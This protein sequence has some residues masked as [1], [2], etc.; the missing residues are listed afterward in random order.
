MPVANLPALDDD[1]DDGMEALASA[2]SPLHGMGLDPLAVRANP[3]L[4]NGDPAA[5]KAPTA[6]T[7]ASA[8]ATTPALPEGLL[9][10][11]FSSEPAAKPSVAAPAP[12]MAAAAAPS[13]AGELQEPQRNDPAYQRYLEQFAID[14]GAVPG[15]YVYDQR[16]D[17]KTE[18]DLTHA[19]P[20]FERQ[21]MDV[22]GV[23]EV[24]RAP[25]PAEQGAVAV[26]PRGTNAIDVLEPEA[27]GAATQ[28]HELEHKYQQSR[29]QQ[30]YRDFT[31]AEM[32]DGAPTAAAY[33]YGGPQGLLAMQKQ[34]KKVTDLNEEQQATM[35]SDY[36]V[37]HNYLLNKAKNGTLT[38][39]DLKAAADLHDAYHPLVAQ[40]AKMVSKQ[41][42]DK[43]EA[44]T[45]KTLP[46]RAWAVLKAITEG[47]PSLGVP[48]PDAPGLPRADT[49]GLGV[50]QADP[51]MGGQS[52]PVRRKAVRNGSR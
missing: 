45:P 50:L 30:P 34:G 51:L 38:Q 35:L 46:Q 42:A 15:R 1:A 6:A 24:V 52:Q 43:A 13:F 41:Q 7:A 5:T 9:P 29:A 2:A 10:S 23:H 36:Q 20:V 12:E 48:Q 26:S 39:Q 18:V 16:Y 40:L 11:P 27:Y 22:A 28:E 8:G 25:Q 14:G 49:P 4:L 21:N 3:A 33:D 31:P 44:E 17:P 19:A 37:A 47:P 32:K